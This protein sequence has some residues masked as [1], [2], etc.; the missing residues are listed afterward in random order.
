MPLNIA[1]LVSGRGSNMSAILDAIKAGRLDA[2]VKMVLS[3]NPE[4]QGLNIA[5]SHGIHAGAIDHKGLKR[6]EHEKKM[7]G[8]LCSMEIDFVVLAGYMRVLTPAFLAP[9]KAASGDRQYFK[10]IN[11]HPSMLPDFPGAHAYDDA[12]A[13]GVA[14]S[15][16]TV[17][18]IDELVDHGPILA[19]ESFDRLPA[20]TLDDFKAR[21]LAVEH[22]LYPAVLQRISQEGIDAI[23][24]SS[25]SRDLHPAEAAG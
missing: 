13:A 14:K 8:L 11:I 22:K 23:L 10:I 25:P 7:L 24:Q 5:R 6:E 20:D 9:F 2:Q 4:A 1:I 15:G 12:F 21:G 17:H 18:L 3:N 19:Q 16:I